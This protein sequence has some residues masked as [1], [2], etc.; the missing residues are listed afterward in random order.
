LSVI[1]IVSPKISI[2]LVVLISLILALVNLIAFFTSNIIG[3]LSYENFVIFLIS[4]IPINGDA[5]FYMLLSIIIVVGALMILYKMLGKIGALMGLARGMLWF[6]SFTVFITYIG[7]LL[8]SIDYF[9]GYELAISTTWFAI[10]I[11]VIAYIA[12]I[13]PIAISLS[14]K[15]SDN[16]MEKVT[17]NN[18]VLENNDILYLKVYGDKDRIKI[19]SEP[20]DMIELSGPHKYFS[21]WLYEIIPIGEG[22]LRL[23]F[24]DSKKLNVYTM[25]NVYIRNI[26]VRHY[27]VQIFI[28]NSK[29]D[30]I[31]ITVEETKTLRQALMPY[32]DSILGRLSIP[33]G[34]VYSITYTNALNKILNPDTRIKNLALADNKILRIYITITE[35]Y[36]DLMLMLG[37]RSVEELWDL[38]IRRIAIMKKKIE[39]ISKKITTITREIDMIIDS[40]W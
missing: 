29:I 3:Y 15:T 1:N 18:I 34:R 24:V 10:N 14:K 36:K 39:E 30:E 8:K 6:A 35:E 28:N 32:I 26:A 23:S 12:N 40:W 27:V 11:V 37:S 9:N 4:R 7:L 25:Y 38:I 5:V 17:S 33:R 21:Y 19:V 31:E 13:P 22:A 20:S 16:K 2:L